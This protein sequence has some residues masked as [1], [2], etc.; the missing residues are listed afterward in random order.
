M[1]HRCSCAGDSTDSA[2]LPC[3]ANFNVSLQVLPHDTNKP[4][5]DECQAQLKGSLT[6]DSY[7]QYCEGAAP[8][9]FSWISPEFVFF[10]FFMLMECAIL[11]TYSV[12]KSRIERR[13]RGMGKSEETQPLSSPAASE[14]TTN[15]HFYGYRES[16]LG[17]LVKHSIFL[18]SLGW[19]VVLITLVCD[20]YEVFAIWSNSNQKLIFVDH[21]NLSKVFVFF[22]HVTT[23]WFLALQY[24]KSFLKTWFLTPTDIPNATFILVEKRRQKAVKNDEMGQ[25]VM[26]A[27]KIESYFSKNKVSVS[28]DLKNLQITRSGRMYIE[29]ECVRYVF[30]TKRNRFEPYQF[31]LG[32]T[33]KEILALASGI[34]EEEAEN[35]IELSGPNQILFAVDTLGQGLWKEFTGIFYLYQLMMLFIWYFYAYYYMGLVL[36]VIIIGSG[37]MKV[38]VSNAAQQRVLEMAT[39]TGY[40]KVFRNN[41]WTEI[42]SKELVVGDV[43]EV[44]LTGLPLSIDCAILSGDVVVDESS[45]TGEALPVTKFSLKDDNNPFSKEFNAKRNC[46]FAGTI[47]LETQKDKQ[48][49][50]VKAIVLST[51]GSTE[52]GKLVRDILYPVPFVFVFTEHLKIVVPILICWGVIMLFASIAILQAASIG[53]WF[54]G[55]FGISQ[56]L[57]P[58]LPA[59]LVINQSV[60]ADRLR[61]KGIMCVDLNRITLAGKV[62]VFCFDKTGTLTKE[63]LDFCGAL[64]VNNTTKTL[65]KIES[66]FASFSYPLQFAMQTCHSISKVQNRYVGNFVDIEMFKYTQANLD[67]NSNSTVIEKDTGKEFKVLKRF[68]F[69]HAHAYMSSVAQDNSTGERH[70]FLK[71]SFEKI[72]ELVDPKSVPEGFVAAAKEQALQGYYVLAIAGRKLD[73]KFTPELIQKATREE[74]EAGSEIIALILFRNE[75][76]QDTPEALSHLREGGCRNIMITGDHANTAVF[77]G[78]QSG[79]VS[80]DSFGQS[81]LILM[82][83]C[84]DDELITWHDVDTGETYPQSKVER[85]V[86][87]GRQGGRKVEL[88]VAGKAFSKLLAHH[89]IPQFLGDIRIFAR[90]SPL[91]KVQCVRLHMQHHITAMCGDGGNDAGALKAAHAGIALCGTGTSVVSHFSSIDVSLR[92]CVELIKEARC[93]LDVSL[94]SYKLLIMYGE[95]LTFSGLIQYFFMVQIS[96]AM[97]IFIDGCTVPLSWALTMAEPAKRLIPSRPT[98]RLLGFET[99]FSAFYHCNQFD[100]TYVDLRKWWELADNYEGELIGIVTTFQIIHSACVFSLGSKYRKGFLNNKTFIAIYSI[101]FVLLSL[102]LLLNPNPISCIFHI[103]CGTQDVLQSLGYSVWWDAPSVYFNTSGH[104]VIPV[105]F[106][107]TVFFIVLFNLAALLAWEGFVILGPVR[108]MAKKFADG[109]WQVKKH[110]IRI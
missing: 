14:P 43:M 34:S 8:A 25:I 102:L 46:L 95:I 108:K 80:I 61:K 53:T 64:Q 76:K 11:V 87:E 105:E 93:S 71:G 39:F 48:G 82:A 42:P 22:W 63:G 107:W 40:A 70:I 33:N 47:V 72:L 104:N 59:V 81:P 44:R 52:K 99:V 97:W 51:G 89:W 35:R 77:I 24:N 38:F 79:L 106:R 7:V 31:N 15:I 90:M 50:C 20:Y 101:G 45:L 84:D 49:E 78:K 28:R 56:V 13:T 30:S 27:Q 2:Y 100:S 54:Y 29:F 4:L 92:S 86:Y 96:Q 57:S 26:W 69:V 41:R 58:L 9:L 32:S 55:M 68:E 6:P 21:D 109:R 36:T 62:K 66:M 60:A 10:Y 73:P 103:N 94:A 85:S 110:P 88:V 91:D 12:Y 83:E 16:F 74:M 1:D 18:T 23:I 17:N 67:P 3:K 98:A 5:V 19:M 65:G 37:V 75:L